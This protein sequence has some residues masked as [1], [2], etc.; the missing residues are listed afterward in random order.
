VPYTPL[1]I[2]CNQFVSL[3][4]CTLC[5]DRTANDIS[6]V[7]SRRYKSAV[8]ISLIVWIL[9]PLEQTYR[10]PDWTPTDD[11]AQHRQNGTERTNAESECPQSTPHSRPSRPTNLKLY[12]NTQS[13]SNSDSWFFRRLLTSR[14]VSLADSPSVGIPSERHRQSHLEVEATEGRWTTVRGT[15]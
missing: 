7:D 1:C 10:T 3:S 2:V 13:S 6:G 15:G 5:H 4:P 11:A 12:Y 8:I 9:A 14:A